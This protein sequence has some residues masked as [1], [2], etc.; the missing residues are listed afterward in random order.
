ML[1]AGGL[2]GP[3]M[4]GQGRGAERGS[5]NDGGCN[6][7]PA[8]KTDASELGHARLQVLQLLA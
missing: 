3:L 5:V 8:V 2:W 1:L 6:G 7:P 4:G